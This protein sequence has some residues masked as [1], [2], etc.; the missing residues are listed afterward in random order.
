MGSKVKYIVDETT[1]GVYI[2]GESLIAYFED[3][4]KDVTNVEHRA[5]VEV[6][7][8][9]LKYIVRDELYTKDPQK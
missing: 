3:G 5:V 2:E 6:I 4:I 7:I 1:D 8:D 9:L